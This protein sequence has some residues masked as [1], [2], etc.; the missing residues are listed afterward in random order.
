MK[1]LEVRNVSKVF[2]GRGG[3]DIKV[4]ED[5]TF[6]IDKEEFVC[7]VGPSGCG[8]STLLRIIA[9]LIP[10]TTGEVLFRG[11]K[12]TEVPRG[13]SMVFQNFALLP[14]LTVLENVE[15]G[16]EALGVPREAR[17]EIAMR[18]I[19]LVGLEGFEDAL[20]RELSGGMK[21]RVG[22]AR[23]LATEPVL[24]LMDEP[25][26]ALDE[27]TAQS[28][29]SDVLSLWANPEVPLQAVVM[30]TH[31]VEEAVFMADRILVLSGRPGRVVADVRV[32]L[33]R[34]RDTRSEEFYAIVDDV[35]SLIA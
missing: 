5:V 16:L 35:L 30:V 32:D 15:L 23:A 2:K 22:F 26:S 7:I 4:L 10:P 6:S 34:P 8:K 17:R 20:P 18:W 27:L 9:G 21:Q 13:V 1:L 25:F 14:W 19:R 29:R 31:N 33:P 24:L 3:R 11:E 12:V 28:L